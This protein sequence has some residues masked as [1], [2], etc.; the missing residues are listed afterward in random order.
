MQSFT[1]QFDNNE[2]MAQAGL[3][4]KEGP[5]YSDFIA[6]EPSSMVPA[7]LHLDIS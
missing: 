7:P 6:L 2:N 3:F 4:R 1:Q 5:K